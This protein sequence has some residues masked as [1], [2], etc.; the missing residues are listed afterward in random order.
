MGAS[1]GSIWVV[2]KGLVESVRKLV[3]KTNKGASSSKS[4]IPL[5]RIN[6]DEFT[7]VNEISF[8]RPGPIILIQIVL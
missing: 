7:H 6:T 2:T 8:S 1:R 3:K 4:K 5:V